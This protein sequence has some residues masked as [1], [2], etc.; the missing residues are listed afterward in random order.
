MI[1]LQQ[2]FVTQEQ[3]FKYWQESKVEIK[4][5]QAKN[6]G[7]RELLERALDDSIEVLDLQFQA[8]P[9]KQTRYDNQRR[10]VL[11]IQE[12]LGEKND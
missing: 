7:L 8:L 4:K 12:A 2:P 10:F 5:L 3:K 1:D 9:Y 11:E 6:S